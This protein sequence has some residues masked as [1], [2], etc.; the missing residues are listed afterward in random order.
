MRSQASG[1]GFELLGL[2]SIQAGKVQSGSSR[3]YGFVEGRLAGVGLDHQPVASTQWQGGACILKGGVGRRR[4]PKGLA[5]RGIVH[6]H[7]ILAGSW[8][9]LPT[10]RG[11]VSQ[12]RRATGTNDGWDGWIVAGNGV[13]AMGT[14]NQTRAFVG[15]LGCRLRLTWISVLCPSFHCLD[16]KVSTLNLHLRTAGGD[17][18][19]VGVE[20]G[21]EG[22]H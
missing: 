18:L 22:G 3:R 21:A 4:L 8:H 11:L 19:V 9:G 1:F 2:G 17:Q 5:C 6:S 12:Y 20:G 15:L 14:F 13:A 7:D 16:A 10:Q